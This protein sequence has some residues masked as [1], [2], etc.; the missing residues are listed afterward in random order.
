MTPRE[1][2]DRVEQLLVAGRD[3]EALD[4]SARF[5]PS[6]RPALSADEMEVLSGMMHKAIMLVKLDEWAEAQ[7]GAEARDV[8]PPEQV[9][10]R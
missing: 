7:S 9:A 2:L 6:V 5:G 4:F 10:P 8:P 1:Y 3:R